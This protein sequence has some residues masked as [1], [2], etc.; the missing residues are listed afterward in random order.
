MTQVG[1][2]PGLTVEA[3]AEVTVVERVLRRSWDGVL[4]LHL[5]RVHVHVQAAVDVVDIVAVEVL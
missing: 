5:E 1:Q 2:R 4:H 3:L